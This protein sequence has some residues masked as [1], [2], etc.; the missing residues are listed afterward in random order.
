M[1]GGWEI[2]FPERLAEEFARL[3]AGERRAVYDLLKRLADEPRG[4]SST[5]EPITAAELRRAHSDPAADSGDR[6]TVLYRIHDKTRRLQLI[7]FLAGP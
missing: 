2:D 1:S 7:W 3:S 6:V 5:R 4:D